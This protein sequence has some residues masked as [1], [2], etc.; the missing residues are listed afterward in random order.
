M[1]PTPGGDHQQTGKGEHHQRP[2]NLGAA[3]QALAQGTGA[4]DLQTLGRGQFFSLTRLFLVRLGHTLCYTPLPGPAIRAD[5][6][7]FDTHFHLSPT[8]DL[9]HL[10]SQARTAGVTR[11]LLAG[12][13]VGQ[14]AAY[15]AR[16]A[17]HPEIVAAVGVHPHEAADFDG[18]Y[19]AYAQLS[20]ASQVRAIGEIGL[21]YHYNHSPAPIQREVLRRFLQLARERGLPAVIHCREAY[22]DTEAILRDELGGQHRF[23]VHCF[24]GTPAWAER[25]LALGGYLS[26]TGLITFP[27]AENVRESL[28]VTPLDRVFFETDSPYL[29]PIPHR[30]KP[31]QPA[32][33]P[34]VV[35]RAAQ[36]LGQDPT[37][38]A[39]Y[40]TATAE[41]FFGL[42]Q[43]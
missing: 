42:S 24:S 7:Y 1:P 18:D 6:M 21:D 10:L 5:C 37:A 22:E 25:F 29:A 16:I 9:P 35:A 31:N 41:R 26:Y 20:Q 2:G 39:H 3:L 12:A 27:K 34:L 4:R 14:M 28:R 30:G 32:F 36:E 11:L 43:L 15:L 19:A 38:F 13:P 23:V 8:D 33:V 40:S 17:A